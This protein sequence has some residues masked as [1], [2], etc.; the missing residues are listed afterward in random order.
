MVGGKSRGGRRELGQR[1]DTVGEVPDNMCR[2]EVAGRCET[3]DPPGDIQR[4]PFHIAR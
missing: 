2:D 4:F 3:H 1:R